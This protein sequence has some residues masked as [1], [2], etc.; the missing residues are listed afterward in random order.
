MNTTDESIFNRTNSTILEDNNPMLINLVLRELAGIFT[1]VT[2]ALSICVLYKIKSK[3]EL[4]QYLMVISIAEF[5]YSLLSNFY[6]FFE[7]YIPDL[8]FSQILIMQL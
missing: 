5:L 3:N 4:F 6:L 1:M 8:Y 7:Y 2:N